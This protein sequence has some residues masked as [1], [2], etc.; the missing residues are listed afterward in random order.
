MSI[1]YHKYLS[2]LAHK[3]SSGNDDRIPQRSPLTAPVQTKSSSI[4]VSPQTGSHRRAIYAARVLS[5]EFSIDKERT[6]VRYAKGEQA[7]L[8]LKSALSN[9]YL[10]SQLNTEDMD[11]V[12]DCMQPLAAVRNEIIT[13]QGDFGKLFYCLEKGNV[14]CSVNGE[15][16]ATYGPYGCF[17]EL[18]LIYNT[19][20]AASI[21]ATSPC[22]LWTLDLSTFRYI[23]TTTYSSKFSQR[24]EFLKK[25]GFLDTVP[26]DIIG[27]LA[28]C[29]IPQTV[30][31]D[32]CILKQ[33]QQSDRLYIIESGAVKC[34]HKRSNG[35]EVEVLSL[36]AGEYFGGLSTSLFDSRH[37]SYTAVMKT[38]LL[39]LDKTQFLG[40]LGSEI[41]RISNGFM[42]YI[43]RSVPLFSRLPDVKLNHLIDLMRPA[44]FTAGD[45]ILRQGEDGTTFYII[46]SGEV[47]CVRR[48]GGSQ[49]SIREGIVTGAYSADVAN[50]DEEELTRLAAMEYF[51]ERG[52]FIQE[53]RSASVLAVG[54]C[55]VKCMALSRKAFLD[56]SVELESEQRADTEAS[57]MAKKAAIASSSP[58]RSYFF[59]DLL[60]MRTLGTGTF[61]RVKLVHHLSTNETFAIK[62]MNKADIV[63]SNQQQNILSEKQL[64]MDC[65]N[66]PFII[67]LVKTFNRANQIYMLMEFIQGGELW[68]YIYERISLVPRNEKGGFQLSSIKFYIANIVIAL[69]YLHSKNIAYRDL[70]PENLVVDNKGYIK[71]VDFGFAKI[72]PFKKDGVTIDKTYTLCGTPEY[73]APEIVLLKGYDKSVDLWALGCLVYELHLV[74]TPFQDET[75]T[76]IFENIVRSSELEIF[77]PDCDELVKDLVTQL[78]D[79][80]PVFRA[81][82]SPRDGIKALKNHIFFSDVSWTEIGAHTYPAPFIPLITNALDCSN[83]D[84]Y[85]EV[86]EIPVYERSQDV[87]ADF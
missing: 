4:N 33:G 20:R 25:C 34:V 3:N 57:N 49:R 70:K 44:E 76:S 9:H 54:P 61:G 52:L 38:K 56:F 14:E 83:F 16:V 85:D 2:A 63:A 32:H 75:T 46:C 5:V 80:N 28:D 65:R 78:L 71:I 73:L 50:A 17:G 27:S 45:V 68:S 81:G 41:K 6:L 55:A 48:H 86:E 11:R 79:V 72:I 15:V 42:S 59:E 12:I 37:C 7:R 47:R 67:N 82:A 18:A 26:N 66:C 43:L 35:R 10:F 30:D 21:T 19:A 62:A 58:V 39:E 24:C 87:F 8:F 22:Q 29:L 23:S 13:S 51:G 1:F 53:L 77:P 74:K 64:L 40:L 84:V 36:K 31:E 69:E 60:M